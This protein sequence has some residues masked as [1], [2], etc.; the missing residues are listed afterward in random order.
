MNNVTLQVKLKQ[1]L[2]KI[3]SQ[4]YD[5]I[6]SWEIAEAFNKAQIEWVRRQLAGTNMRKEGDEMSKRRIDDLEILL[7]RER[8]FGVDVNYNN[9]FGYFESSN[10]GVIYDPELGGDY[11]E[12]KKIEC[13]AQ[14]C[15]A[16]QPATEGTPEIPGVPGVAGVDPIPGVPGYTIPGPDVIEIQQVTT[17]EPRLVTQ[18]EYFTNESGGGLSP[19][20]TDPVVYNANQT[21]PALTIPL[22]AVPNLLID[23]GFT[24]L[25][26]MTAQ[27]ILDAILVANPN[28]EGGIGNI[29][30]GSDGCWYTYKTCREV[31]VYITVTT[32]VEVLVPGPDI[33]VDPIP[34][35][36]GIDP[37]PPIP[38]V[39]AVP[40]QE[41]V[42]CYCAPGADQENFCTN[43]RQ[44]TVYQSE[45]ANI[46]VIL[47]D[48]L[49]NPNWEWGE[50]F[51]TFQEG[52]SN[53]NPLTLGPGGTAGIR[54]WRKDFFIM[55]PVLVY[56]RTPRRIQ[57]AGSID[58]YTG[59][60]VAVDVNCEFKDDIV[61]LMIDY[62]ASILAGDISDMNQYQRGSQ[63]SEKNN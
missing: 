9:T 25:C 60:A 1:R 14:Q 55:N 53:F 22:A 35:V 18:C 63:E 23:Q 28:W 19:Y 13:G 4:D 49:K 34:G 6:Q 11:L 58:P 29:A 59:Q 45:V 36:P 32:D 61:E 50:T 54:I 21:D 46:D 8:L 17:R 48:P 20:I 26:G 39:P 44:M 42:S 38:A 27:E 41:A 2:N 7:K 30:Q 40:P 15:F 51:C 3:D 10:F 5:N 57:I 31:T 37:I 24:S 56:Y 43:A 16:D 12:F 47:R 52:E 62:A 33:I